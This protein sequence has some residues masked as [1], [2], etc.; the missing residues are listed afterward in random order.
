MSTP[1]KRAISGYLSTFGGLQQHLPTEV[2][3][4]LRNRGC[5]SR[6]FDA[7]LPFLDYAWDKSVRDLA[8][9]LLVAWVRADHHNAT[10]AANHL[11]I[12]ADRLHAGVNLQGFT[13]LAVAVI[14][15]AVNKPAS[16]QCSSG[17]PGDHSLDV[18]K[19]AVS[20]TTDL[21]VAVNDT[22]SVEIVWAHFYLHPVLW[23]DSNVV[24]AHFT[25]DSCKHDVLVG[26]F[27]AEHCVRQCFGH[28]ALY[29]DDTF[30]LG[31]FPR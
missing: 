2:V 3:P 17:R 7:V 30:L 10:I 19:I 27:D 21:L 16:R 23:E 15:G 20:K 5:A 9:T 18:R 28:C 1:A 14:F 12:V 13:P 31:H 6:V 29:L 25:R 11:A 4:S 24:L 8:L 26:Q 22:T